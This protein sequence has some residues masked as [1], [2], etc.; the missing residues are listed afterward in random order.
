MDVGS[1]PGA[2]SLRLLQSSALL[3]LRTAIPATGSLREPGSAHP[4]DATNPNIARC[5][6]GWTL[7]TT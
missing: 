2:E 4:K 6:Y 7:A 5:I 3:E 1:R